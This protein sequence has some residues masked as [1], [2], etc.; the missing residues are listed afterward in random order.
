MK[1]LY[2]SRRTKL[3]DYLLEQKIDIAMITSPANVFYYTGF[4]SD[5]HERFMSLIDGEA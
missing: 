1:E 5:P 3:E 4:K 2:K